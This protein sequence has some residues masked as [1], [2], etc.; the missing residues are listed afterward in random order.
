MRARVALPLEE[1][2]PH[3]RD[4]ADAG[5]I[6]LRLVDRRE[7]RARGQ[8]RRGDPQAHAAADRVSHGG[9]HGVAD[10]AGQ[11]HVVECEVQ[12]MAGV[13][14]PGHETLRDGLGLLPTVLQRP[15]MQH[16][17]DTTRR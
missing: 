17:L 8:Q 3:L 5:K 6:D 11:A 12:T 4:V 2:L 1:D 14:E 13:A 10:G 15:G 9:G 16:V 7:D